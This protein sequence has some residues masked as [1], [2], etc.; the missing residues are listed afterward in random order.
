[1]FIGNTTLIFLYLCRFVTSLKVVCL[2]N[3]H[4]QA[5]INTYGVYYSYYRSFR[6]VNVLKILIF[7][8]STQHADNFWTF[9]VTGRGK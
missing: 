6:I 2:D 3:R 5:K 8:T 9:P 1:M 7:M 4:A